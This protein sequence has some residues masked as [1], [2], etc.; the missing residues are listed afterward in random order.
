MMSGGVALTEANRVAIGK[1]MMSPDVIGGA[2][3]T[4]GSTTGDIALN[5]GG[6]FA[7][8]K[9]V[10]AGAGFVTGIAGAGAEFVAGRFEGTK[11]HKK[12]IG[13]TAQVGAAAGLGLAAGPIGAA[14]GAGV[15][16]LSWGASQVLGM[17][18]EKAYEESGGNVSP[19]RTKYMSAKQRY[20]KAI[21]EGTRSNW[22]AK[23]A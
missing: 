11:A 13:F 17:V 2:T 8:V 15:G 21:S 6:R 12:K 1:A 22:C 16:A 23:P 3:S 20:D 4:F 10:Q 18:I 19:S 5:V 7:V 9:G 14:A